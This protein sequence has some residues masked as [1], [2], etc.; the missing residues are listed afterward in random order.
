MSAHPGHGI[1]ES[2]LHK[3]IDTRS[4]G[5]PQLLTLG[6]C[7]LLQVIDGYDV[8]AM[9][10]AAP[11]LAQD[12]ALSPDRLGLVFSAGVLGMTLGAMLLAPLTDR[13]GRRTMIIRA[14]LV[15]GVSMLAT[16]WVESLQAMVIIRVITG[17][18]IG[19]MLAS[20]T[21]LVSEF[22]PDRL[23][24]M[25]V[26][27]LLAG[28]PLGA[29]LGG[30]LAA[31]LIPA[32]GWQGVF[33]AGGIMTLCLLP[34]VLIY[35]PESL[36]F[37]LR[38]RPDACLERMNEVLSYLQIP[39][40][41]AVPSAGAEPEAANVR[42]LLTKS[43]RK[44][45][46]QLW[47]SF[48]LCFGTLYFLLSWIPKLLVDSGLSLSQ[49]ISAGIAFNIGGVLG[50]ICIGWASTRLGL[51]KT[52]LYFHLIAASGML[53]FAWL[54]LNIA[55]L[56]WLAGIIGLFQQGGF[57]GFYMTAVRLY[58]P[59]IRTTG[60]GWGIGLGRFGAVIA[61]YLAGQL[62]ALGWGIGILF[63]VFA[64]PLALGGWITYSIRSKDL[65]R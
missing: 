12:W 63:T 17:L 13:I 65:P 10:F 8:L 43:R 16:A 6:V 28:Y 18:T 20:L 51:Q 11:T 39:Q 44:Q 42:S 55:G 14:M 48:F 52:I 5:R 58:P 56:L 32:Y 26:G 34:L 24:N 45:T 30:F 7:F 33:V 62:I 2:Q 9:S 50:N 35:V 1:T 46:L 3:M 15:M 38:R 23:R 59:E 54:P 31:W 27:I 36:Y 57:V 22:F 37:L 60:V 40:L 4:P 61:P 29:I 25:A 53:L 21:S 47:S 19:A 49:A 41:Q 64:I